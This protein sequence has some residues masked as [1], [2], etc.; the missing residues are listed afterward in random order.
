MSERTLPE[1]WNFALSTAISELERLVLQFD[2]LNEA[3]GRNFVGLPTPQ[4]FEIIIQGFLQE[5]HHLLQ[6]DSARLQ[7]VLSQ[8]K[9]QTKVV[10]CQGVKAA[11]NQWNDILL[12]KQILATMQPDEVF[13]R[14]QALS[15]QY[16]FADKSWFI[17]GFCKTWWSE[18]YISYILSQA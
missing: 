11:Q 10:Y 13:L 3:Q 12:D 14:A 6:G 18:E 16:V 7:T 15:Q 9:E 2:F 4:Q 17:E 1:H 5:T 8:V